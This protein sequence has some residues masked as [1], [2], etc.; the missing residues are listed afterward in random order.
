MGKVYNPKLQ[1]VPAAFDSIT[2]QGKLRTLHGVLPGDDNDV[3][4]LIGTHVQGIAHTQDD[5]FLSYNRVPTA[6][7]G[8]L[9]VVSKKTG[10]VVHW[11]YTPQ[12]SAGY[13]H[14]GGMQI[15]G[16]YLMVPIEN[17]QHNQSYIH[18]YDLSSMTDKVPPQ[19]LAYSLRR[20]N[21]SGAAGI[22]N[23][24]S[25]GTEYYLMV[26]YDNGKLYFYRSNG[27]TL[28]DEAFALSLL[29]TT[30]VSQGGYSSLCLVTDKN[31]GVYMIGFWTE[32]ADS[33]PVDYMDL[34]SVDIGN[35]RVS[36]V[37]KSRHMIT[38]YG[39]IVG[40]AGV[41]F[42]FGAGLRIL[43]DTALKAY[44]TQRNFVS[45]ALA[46]NGFAPK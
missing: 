9:A 24:T 20:H 33:A 11:I 27:L 25:G 30:E 18:F 7:T 45:G 8:L 3:V 16:D 4:D 35:Q 2:R 1:D 17:W 31:N 46:S 32:A 12:E 34:Y 22:T 21:G 42:R 5:I 43:S 15:I 40:P 14:P 13:Q 26:A 36:D 6:P 37:L 44:A 23:Y 19:P 38:Q 41:H 39:D 29:F 10:W 28:A